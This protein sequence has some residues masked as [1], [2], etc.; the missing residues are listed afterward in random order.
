MPQA[1]SFQQAVEELTLLLLYLSSWEEEFPP[2][3]PIGHRAWKGFLFEALDA[4]ERQGYLSQTRQAKSVALTAEG[5]AKAKALE[6]KY[7]GS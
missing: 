5:I 4:L 1:P 3:T 2:G 7:L 6:A